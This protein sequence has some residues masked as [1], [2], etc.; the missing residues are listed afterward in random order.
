LALLLARRSLTNDAGH[1]TIK[2]LMTR[3]VSL[4][5]RGLNR[6]NLQNWRK[7][8]SRCSRIHKQMQFVTVGP[9]VELF[10]FLDTLCESELYCN[11]VS[12]V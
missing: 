9:F 11:A 3:H 10:P 1:F 12:L 5:S 4:L 6:P 8:D 7:K 2:E